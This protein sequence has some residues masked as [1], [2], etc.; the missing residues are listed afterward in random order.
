MSASH[1][2]DSS[3]SERHLRDEMSLSLPLRPRQDPDIGSELYREHSK[4]ED[5]GEDMIHPKKK[6]LASVGG[7]GP[8]DRRSATG[9]MPVCH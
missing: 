4:R 2:N 9:Y 3:L 5:Q 6:R 7:Q 8:T 1:G